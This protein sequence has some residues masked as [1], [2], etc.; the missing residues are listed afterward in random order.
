MLLDVPNTNTDCRKYKKDWGDPRKN[1][2]DW[3]DWLF[4]NQ[5]T[6]KFQNIIRK[7]YLYNYYPVQCR[8]LGLALRKDFLLSWENIDKI[9]KHL[10]NNNKFVH[11]EK[12]GQENFLAY[13]LYLRPKF[14]VNI[15][16]P[17]SLLKPSYYDELDKFRGTKV[18]N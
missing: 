5:I 15:K 12:R 1:Q 7:E 9:L 4:Q 8:D 6:Y 13:H 17:F 3:D 11:V 16:C 10:I 18:Q 14:S 2:R